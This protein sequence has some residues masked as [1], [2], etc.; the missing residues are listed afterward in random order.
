MSGLAKLQVTIPPE[1]VH[2]FLSKLH[3]V[4]ESMIG[5]ELAPDH[6]DR[7]M[8]QL[9][10]GHE[11]ESE[12][13]A[14]KIAEIAQKMCCAYRSADAKVLINR[15]DRKVPFAQDPHPELL[16][17]DE[18][19]QYGAGRY[20]LGPRLWKLVD[21]FDREIARWADRFK[22]LP[23]QF[24]SL[25]GAD[26]LDRCKYLRS[27]PHALTFVSHLREDLGAIQ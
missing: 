2:D 6:R 23:H 14:S 10:P 26:A 8:F 24:P 12:L 7:V 25:V 1:L 19:F 3:Y 18:L 5:F 21:F 16:A 22:A 13:V 27:F 17:Q 4:S 9:R 15:L 20:G 11:S